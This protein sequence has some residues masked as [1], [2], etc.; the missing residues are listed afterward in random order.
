MSSNDELDKILQNLCE[1]EHVSFDL[2]QSLLKV[3][4]DYQNKEKRFGIFEKIK[5]QIEKELDKK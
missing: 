1:E 3:E 4:K 2:L 5:N